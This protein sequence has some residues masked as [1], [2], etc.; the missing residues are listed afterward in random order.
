[1]CGLSWCVGYYDC[2]EESLEGRDTREA[3]WHLTGQLPGDV[4]TAQRIFVV[5]FVLLV[6]CFSDRTEKQPCV[7]WNSQKSSASASLALDLKVYSTLNNCMQ[8]RAYLAQQPWVS[9]FIVC[10]CEALSLCWPDRNPSELP[11][12][13]LL[14]SLCSFDVSGSGAVLDSTSLK[15]DL[16]GRLQRGF[17]RAFL[18][19]GNLM[20]LEGDTAETSASGMC[21]QQLVFHFSRS[22]AA[23][24]REQRPMV[25]Q[26]CL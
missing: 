12:F 7:T 2:S 25:S 19:R 24:L 13:L 21:P 16:T 15:S 3:R 23:Y 9:F 20:A 6:F 4:W 26:L 18:C 14:P 17:L 5:V 1:M 11:S 22:C 8:H 10:F